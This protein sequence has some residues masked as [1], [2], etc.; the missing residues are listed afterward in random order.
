MK[1][2]KIIPNADSLMVDSR[3]LE[4]MDD[5]EIQIF[6]GGNEK[7]KMAKTPNIGKHLSQEF[8]SSTEV[9]KKDVDNQSSISRAPSKKKQ[10]KVP[11]LDFEK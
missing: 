9:K 4:D 7:I 2:I 3:S 11:K 8:P 6:P 10:K 5:F 1:K